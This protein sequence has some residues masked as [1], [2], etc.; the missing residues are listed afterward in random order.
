[1]VTV[2]PRRTSTRTI[3]WTCTEE[4]FEP[5]MGIPRSAH[6]YATRCG[7]RFASAP[8]GMSFI[9]RRRRAQA[10]TVIQQLHHPPRQPLE[11]A[12]VDA[13]ARAQVGRR[14]AGDPL[15]EPRRGGRVRREHLDQ[16][17][18]APALRPHQLLLARL[19]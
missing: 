7:S 6:T 15:A 2:A 8:A 4:P 18:F 3:A 13:G 11:P 17:E 12:E 5:Q 14:S 10:F 19:D 9:L 1:M 16:P